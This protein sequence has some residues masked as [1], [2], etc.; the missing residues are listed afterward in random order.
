MIELL[1]CT[2][3]PPSSGWIK[4]AMPVIASILSFLLALLILPLIR[5][6][7]E[8]KRLESLKAVIVLWLEFFISKISFQISNIEKFVEIANEH[9]Y[10]R[11]FPFHVVDIQIDHFLSYNDNDLRK[12]FYEKVEGVSNPQLYIDVLNDLRFVKANQKHLDDTYDKWR[13][14]KDGTEFLPI[15]EISIEQL[16]IAQKSIEEFL[17]VSKSST[18]KADWWIW[19]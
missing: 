9:P 7:N 5:A 2:C 18:I 1:C 13:V 12:V 16:K 8:Q 19:S 3:P 14:A 6:R 4:T 17:E 11:D 15:F 10:Q